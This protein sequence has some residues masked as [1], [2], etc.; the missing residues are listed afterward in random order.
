MNYFDDLQF[1]AADILENYNRP[2]DR[3]CPD[4]YTV[5]F[6][7]SGAML[8]GRDG[9]PQDKIDQP[10]VFW[11]HP[12]HSYQYGP[13]TP[14]G[15]WQHRWISFRGERGR[16]LLE[17]GFMPL[18]AKGFVY[19]SR[20]LEIEQ[21]FH[22]LLAKSSQP[23]P[24]ELAE[25]IVLLEQL[26]CICMEQARGIEE[27]YR[28]RIDEV[29]AEIQGQPCH[30]VDFKKRSTEMGFS[31]SHF[32]RLFKQQTGL[33]PHDYLL[34]CRM[35][36]AADALKDLRRS[37]KEVAIETGYEDPAQFSKLFRQKIG[38]SPKKFR[39]T[40]PSSGINAS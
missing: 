25:G 21:I 24:R 29:C 28:N 2:L 11:H 26:L 10:A 14:T 19:V 5:E 34:H 7:R 1:V 8:H 30:R 15:G 39:Q 27:P 6:I 18:S 22:Q 33:A 13:V 36:Y 31:Y 9:G 32:R 16:R 35:Q 20:P 3:C 17:E 4:I 38:L 23:G 37:V 40:L 12:G